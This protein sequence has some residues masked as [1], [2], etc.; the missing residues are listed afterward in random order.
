MDAREIERRAYAVG[1]YSQL[2]AFW[3]VLAV[4]AFQVVNAELH[5]PALIEACPA[6]KGVK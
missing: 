4:L 6:P 5:P 3:V 1:H 2:L